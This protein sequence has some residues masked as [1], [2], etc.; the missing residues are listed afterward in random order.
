M[1]KFLSF[2]KNQLWC[3]ESKSVFIFFPARQV[4]EIFLNTSSKNT[5]NALVSGFGKR[6]QPQGI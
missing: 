6:P 1:N 3:G 5:E 4:S 2:E